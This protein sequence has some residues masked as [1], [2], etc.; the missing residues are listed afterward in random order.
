MSVLNQIDKKI[1]TSLDCIKKLLKFFPNHIKFIDA[2]KKWPTKIS[3]ENKAATH[4][5]KL[6]L[7]MQENQRQR[8][9]SRV[10]WMRVCERMTPYNL[11]AMHI[12]DTRAMCVSID[13]MSTKFVE[14]KLQIF[15]C[16]SNAEF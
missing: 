5:I 6:H 4:Q 12:A 16:L 15:V 9:K 11:I 1:I 7:K 10:H 14:M 2:R 13:E 8:E 3:I